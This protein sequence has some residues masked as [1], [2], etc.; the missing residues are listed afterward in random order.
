MLCSARIVDPADAPVVDGEVGEVQFAGPGVT[1]GYWRDPIATAAAFTVDGWLRSGDLARRDPDGFVWVAGRRKE[2]FISG[3]EN[4][5]P[6]EVE[7]VLAACP[8]VVDAAVL[9]RPTRNGV[10]V[11]RAFIQLASDREPDEAEQ[12]LR[13]RSRLAPYKVPRRSSYRAEFRARQL[14]K[15]EASWLSGGASGRGSPPRIDSA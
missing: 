9:S 12:P 3:G 1:P 5:Y 10:E 15:P 4:V 7:N 14:A 8:G 13:C 11:G 6:V 2:M